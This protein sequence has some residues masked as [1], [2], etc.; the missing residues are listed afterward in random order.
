LL[1]VTSFYLITHNETQTESLRAAFKA[2]CFN[3]SSDVFFVLIL[4]VYLYQTNSLYI[5]IS[6]IKSVAQIGYT[7]SNALNDSA[8]YIK[9]PYI[10]AILLLLFA[11][12]II[13]SVQIFTFM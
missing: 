11:A 9:K 10:Q 4:V 5:D 2:F 7:D 1:G 12:S 3:L 13:K 6:T 8:I